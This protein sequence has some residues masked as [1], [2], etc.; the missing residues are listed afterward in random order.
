MAE[1]PVSPAPILF[2]SK[3]LYP[4]PT[5]LYPQPK[6]SSPNPSPAA[7]SRFSDFKDTDKHPGHFMT[8]SAQRM[9][10]RGPLSFKVQKEIKIAGNDREATISFPHLLWIETPNPSCCHLWKVPALPFPGNM[11]A[12]EVTKVVGSLTTIALG[13]QWQGSCVGNMGNLLDS[14]GLVCPVGIPGHHVQLRKCAGSFC[15]R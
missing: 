10:L 7:H 5:L 2:L 1:I 6:L 8:L 13:V 3:A 15:A 4:S 11:W 14:Q 9:T 12:A